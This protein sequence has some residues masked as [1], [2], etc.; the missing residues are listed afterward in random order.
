[1][2]KII[3]GITI[4]LA[5]L[6][7]I[8]LNINAE[9][10]ESKSNNLSIVLETEEGNLESNTFPNKE[11]CTYDKVV[12]ENT[13]DKVTPTFNEDTWKLNLSVEEERVDGNFN[14][15]IYFKEKTYEV[16]TSIENGII[17]ENMKVV[18]RGD[19]VTFSITPNT[20][21]KDV[22]VSCTN[23]Q[24]GSINGNTLTLS[25]ITNNT[26]C[27][28][29]CNKSK[30]EFDFSKTDAL[31]NFY[32]SEGSGAFSIRTT[33]PVGL[34]YN[35]PPRVEGEENATGY[36]YDLDREINWNNFKFTIEYYTYDYAQALG[37]FR[38][39]FGIRYAYDNAWGD[40]GAG[41][42][43]YSRIDDEY[44]LNKYRTTDVANFE[45]TVVIEKNDIKIMV[46]G[47]YSVQTTLLN[48]HS[49]KAKNL[50][51]Y[52]ANYSTYPQTTMVIKKVILEKL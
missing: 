19:A 47:G 21:Y 28:V 35:S 43:L 22:E 25:N 51:I 44:V 11:E 15:N 12:C 8:I 36:T 30:Y 9:G 33:S 14:C 37:I 26:T 13:S 34:R 50:G 46:S 3:V 32:R 49:L 18:K 42:Y 40:L 38:I 29:K 2:K 24:I 6:V 41:A 1:M 39:F 10:E 5:V 16:K 52:M 4:S 20:D 7:V 23:N 27:L 45:G 48:E 31:D 17:D